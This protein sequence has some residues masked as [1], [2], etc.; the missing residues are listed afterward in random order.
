MNYRAF[1]LIALFCF[2]G[3]NA[4]AQQYDSEQEAMCVAKNFLEKKKHAATELISVRRTYN[5]AKPS[6]EK[7]K[8]YYIFNN[9]DNC[10]FV[11]TGGKK[12]NYEI[13]GYST[14]GSIN[15]ADM[16]DALKSL[17][18]IYSEGYAKASAG[19]MPQT[20]THVAIEPMIKTA[21]EQTTPYNDQCPVINGEHCPTGCAA[22]VMA[23]I[24]NYYGSTVKFQ[25]KHEYVTFTNKIEQS[26]DYDA[27]SIDWNL[28]NKEKFVERIN[29]QENGSDFTETMLLETP[30]ARAEVAKLM[31]ACGVALDMDYK[32]ESSSAAPDAYGEAAVKYFGFNDACRFVAREDY[33][34]AVWYAMVYEELEAQRPIAYAIS[35]DV[36]EYGAHAVIVDGCDDSGFMHINWGWES[37]LN[38]YF[39]LSSM[40]QFL[41]HQY[42]MRGLTTS[43]AV[44]LTDYPKAEIDYTLSQT[45][46]HLTKGG[47]MNIRP[48]NEAAR[49]SYYEVTTSN[50]TVCEV[51]SDDGWITIEAKGAGEADVV[52]TWN[53]DK[54]ETCHV[55]VVDGILST[56]R[57]V[58]YD[59]KYDEGTPEELKNLWIPIVPGGKKQLQVEVSKDATNRDVIWSSTF[60]E[61][62]SV[63][64][65]GLVTCHHGYQISA[66]LMY[67]LGVLAEA[68]DGGGKCYFFFDALNP[69]E[70]LKVDESPLALYE[71]SPK[72]QLEVTCT[73]G[74]L[75]YMKVESSDPSV[76]VACDLYGA[77]NDDNLRVKALKPGTAT[78]TIS[79]ND[80]TGEVF[81]REVTVLPNYPIANDIPSAD[82]YLK[83]VA[84][85]QYFY[86]YSVNTGE[87]NNNYH[88][89]VMREGTMVNLTPQ[90][91]DSY[92]KNLEILTDPCR[93]EWNI[94]QYQIPTER[95]EQSYL[96]IK[97]IAYKVADNTYAF[98]RIDHKADCL[99]YDAKQNVFTS[100]TFDINDPRAQWILMSQ[101]EY[102]AEIAETKKAEDE[103]RQAF[104]TQISANEDNPMDVSSL[105]RNASFSEGEY[106]WNVSVNG[107]DAYDH[108]ERV[109]ENGNSGGG[110]EQVL[111]NIPNGKYVLMCQ[112]FYRYTKTNYP[113]DFA[114]HSSYQ[115]YDAAA[116]AKQLYDSDAYRN[117]AYV[118]ANDMETELMPAPAATEQM[119]ASGL[120]DA[121]VAAVGPVS[122]C[123]ARIAFEQGLFPNEVSVLVTDG[124]LRVGTGQMVSEGMDFYVVDDFLLF[125][126]GA[127][128]HKWAEEWTYDQN[129][130]WHRCTDL[131][132]K[133]T[134][135]FE[136]EG[137]GYGEHVYGTEGKSQWMCSCGY[138][139]PILRAK[140]ADEYNIRFAAYKENV[141][142]Q[143]DKLDPA[144]ICPNDASAAE[145][146]IAQ[147]KT[148]ISNVWYDSYSYGSEFIGYFEEAIATIDSIYS[149][150]MD[151]IVTTG[152]RDIASGIDDADKLYYD[153]TGATT[154]KSHRG[155]T[156]LKNGAVVKKFIV[157]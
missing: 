29:Y 53:G 105:I 28:V 122:T 65:N 117:W 81:T 50:S 41:G 7:N 88:G 36:K 156:I 101:A 132:C 32:S 133:N 61:I 69:I 82:Y 89:S 148:D 151:F 47:T 79:R 141:L 125:Y 3:L 39:H 119:M 9:A 143:I 157:K 127:H 60:P 99:G 135:C 130:H 51:M 128:N 25:G 98:C 12:N 84:T 16:P 63:D 113:G 109:F 57:V 8:P 19:S 108:F 146:V 64:Q 155:I 48:L 126:Y 76:V 59:T 73:S 110:I 80:G 56:M 123:D 70:G 116:E 14:K 6:L 114:C 11:I 77:Y 49:Y 83:N 96:N 43:S 52:V 46:L 111:E 5:K 62:L 71:N 31:H 153:A 42:M 1:P 30:E 45:E 17:L 20:P 67:N 140:V 54:S 91:P 149:E 26:F 142:E 68:A 24:L 33:D 78:L 87:P 139:D 93:P 94:Y 15:V 103:A 104:V 23:Q 13:L 147:A 2:L 97:Y 137:A 34:D 90:T 44:S 115:N 75:Q 85:G 107:F 152:I 72:H 35:D 100:N 134:Y 27:L 10:G 124:T 106:G 92:D 38:G 40:R 22:T 21:W 74:N 118:Y 95:P 145:T 136:E 37:I 129:V 4:N 138:E 66:G 121:D 150:L 58:S 112:G 86:D 102:E 18:G 55:T 144:S 131:C 154:N 120:F